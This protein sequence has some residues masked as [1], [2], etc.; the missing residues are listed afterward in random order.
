MD[1]ICGEDSIQFG[2][3]SGEI[4]IYYSNVDVYNN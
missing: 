4:Y 2:D 1:L 3:N